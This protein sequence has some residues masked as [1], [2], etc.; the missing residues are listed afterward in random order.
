MILLFCAAGIIAGIIAGLIP[1]IHTNNIAVLLATS[2]I[3]GI[4]ATAFIL[5]MCTVQVFIDFIPSIFIGAPSETTFEAILPAHKMFLDGRAYEAICYTTFGAIIAIIAGAL[6]TPV[7]FLFIEQNSTE[8]MKSTPAVLAFALIIFVIHEKG[9]K[10]KI[11]AVFVIIAAAT[12]GYLFTNQIFPLIT[13]Y[14]GIAG[15]A[16]SLKDKITPVKQILNAEVSV[17]A[18]KEALIGL[19]GG[20]IVSVMPGIGSNTAGGIIN[21]FRNESGHKNY[22]AMLG[23]INA[24]N[25]FFSF[26]ILFAL[27]KARNGGMLVLAEKIIATPQTLFYG[28][29]IMLICAGIGGLAALTLAKKATK[30]FDEKLIHKASIGAIIL[31][32][33]LVIA[34]NGINGLIALIFSTALGLFVLTQKVHRSLC[35]SALIVPVLFFYIF[36]LI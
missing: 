18:I 28:T 14:F 22:L 27:S 8:I 11:T 24:S 29:I 3:F 2:P 23:A 33:C 34:F 9:W 25:F 4:E 30:I 10:S 35:M 7:F 17:L 1:G 32:I 26:S 6:L 12:Q 31:M 21:T 15:T 5:S 13:G 16:Y 36:I 20:T 19:A